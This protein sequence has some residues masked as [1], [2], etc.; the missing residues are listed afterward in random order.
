M[1]PRGR[2][3]FSVSPAPPLYVDMDGTLLATDVLWELFV[4]LLK[5]R[6]ALLLRVP[7][8]LMKGR[9]Y[10]KQRL[11]S[12]V[13]LDA[14]VLPYRESV[15]TFL[16]REHR[17]GRDIILATASDRLVAERV[18][19]RVGLFSTVLAS[20]GRI[21]LAGR[22][23]LSAILHH[24][25]GAPFDYIGNSL[26]D[27]VIWKHASCALLVHPSRRT[28]SEVDRTSTVQ[29]ILCFRPPLIRGFLRT[30]RVHQWAKNVLLVVPLL[31]AH[32]VTDLQRA[33]HA[34]LAFIAFSLT[35]SAVYVLNDLLDLAS[36]RQ[37][38]YKRLRP[39]AS[40]LVPI[41]AALAIAPLALIG[42]MAIAALVLPALFTAILVLYAG[43]TTA[44][45]FALKR[46][47]ILD[48]LVL[49]GLY[50]LRVLAGAVATD[51][52]VSPWFLAFSMFFFLSLAFVKRY[53][54]LQLPR[55]DGEEQQY[56]RARGYLTSD[57][58]LLRSI[59]G[60]SGY[61]AVAV[62]AFYIHSPEV[63]RLYSQPAVLWVIGPLL[64]YWISRVWLLA[65]RGQLHGDPVVF[66]LT[67]R[68]SY[69]LAVLVAALLI[70]ASLA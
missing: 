59:G 5:T 52:T 15:I 14:A 60:A 47:A 50:T 1:T 53:A 34:L 30:L 54:E 51:V 66:A 70:V 63:H 20:D 62:L 16:A 36:D 23:K 29:D 58:D 8:W 9:A 12:L 25:G 31:L 55:G 41:P 13:T 17:R 48:V 45:S 69:L 33:L 27:R 39:L 18:A 38:P 11:A 42:G 67:D 19:R 32:Q 57:A 68:S 21:N 37:H 49:A 2:G 4:L 61:L 56:L 3:S 10:L 43:T 7:F 24:A 46:I 22:A 64:L 26:A 6:P 35:A 65:H 44:Y 28:V 40:G